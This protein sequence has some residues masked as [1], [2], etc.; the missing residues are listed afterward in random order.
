MLSGSSREETVSSTAPVDF[1]GG[2]HCLWIHRAAPLRETRAPVWWYDLTNRMAQSLATMRATPALERRALSSLGASSRTS[3]G[4]VTRA[5]RFGPSSRVPHARSPLRARAGRPRPRARR[6]PEQPLLL[7]IRRG[8]P[9]IDSLLE[10]YLSKCRSNAAADAAR[11]ALERPSAEPSPASIPPR[12]PSAGK[13]LPHHR[14]RRPRAPPLKRTTSCRPPTSS[15]TTDSS[16]RRSS[17]SSPPTP[18]CCTSASN[19]GT[20]PERR[21]R[22][23]R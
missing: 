17:T 15:S 7:R 6:G 1:R 18:P 8:P 4:A 16:P 11:A 20:T 12:G 23:R 14:R 19:Q 10:L 22:S 2:R 21:T 3:I 13:S 5:G 9:V